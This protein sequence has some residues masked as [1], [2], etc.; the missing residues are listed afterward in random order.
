MATPWC[1]GEITRVLA[2]PVPAFLQENTIKVMPN[3]M[4]VDFKNLRIYWLFGFTK[5][6]QKAFIVQC[7]CSRFTPV[8]N[9]LTNKE[10]SGCSLF[11]N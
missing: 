2:P 5:L 8:F 11:C 3:R 7:C 4:A 1:S 9:H 10:G 6:M